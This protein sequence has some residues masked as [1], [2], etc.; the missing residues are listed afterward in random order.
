MNHIETY[1]KNELRV[2]DLVKWKPLAEVV[3]SHYQE[4]M[5]KMKTTKKSLEMNGPAVNCAG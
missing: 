3:E 4:F 1:R 2:C 5:E